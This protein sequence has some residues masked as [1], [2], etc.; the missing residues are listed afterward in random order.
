MMGMMNSP[1]PVINIFML[2]FRIMFHALDD[3]VSAPYYAFYLNLIT[4]NVPI[5]TYSS[6]VITIDQPLVVTAILLSL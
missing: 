4:I 1:M 2:S 6:I 3:G 5:N